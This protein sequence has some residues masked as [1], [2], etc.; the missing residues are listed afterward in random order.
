MSST[1]A[2]QGETINGA[3]ILNET[4]IIIG[5]ERRRALWCSNGQTNLRL[6]K[7]SIQPALYYEN[8]PVGV[9]YSG[10]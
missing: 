10:L 9:F 3:L 2:S 5:H 7:F 1:A 8:G 6:D 4:P